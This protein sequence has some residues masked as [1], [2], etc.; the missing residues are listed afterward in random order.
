MLFDLADMEQL[1]NFFSFDVTLEGA[2]ED[3]IEARERKF[4]RK[5]PKKGS[6]RVHNEKER[7]E[8]HRPDLK[9]AGS[10]A[11]ARNLLTY[12]L[13]G[14]G[15]PRHWYGYGDETNRATAEAQ[16]A[17]TWRTLETDQDMARDVIMEMLLFVRDQADIAGN[18]HPEEDVAIIVQMPEMSS[19]DVTTVTQ[20][21]NQTATALT[22]VNLLDL[23][24]KEK[25]A[26]IWAKVVSELGV[27]IDADAELK[28]L[29]EPKEEEITA[30][31]W[32]PRVWINDDA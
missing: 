21:L 22:M 14:L 2:D 30:V 17:P 32:L 27:E 11:T 19:R 15:M 8:M 1:A 28:K 6:V 12:I 26:E 29:A 4:R 23:M 18:W 5:P 16:N 9:Q 13:G 10:I 20:A 3:E 24:T 31:E 25:A 7:W